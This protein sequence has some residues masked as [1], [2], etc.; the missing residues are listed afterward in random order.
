MKVA[1]LGLGNMGSGMAGNIL[2]AGHELTVWN[3]TE[4]KTEALASQGAQ[5]ARSIEKAVA[6][7]E[8]VVTCLM[9]D[10][11][12]LNSV[13]G[14]MLQSLPTNAVH[15]CATTIS[16]DCSEV[17]D[18][19]HQGHGSSYVAAP[20]IG[21]PDAAATGDLTSVL[22]GAEK[23]IERAATLADCYSKDLIRLPGSPSRGNI[24]KLC[25]NYSAI[26]IIE[27]MGE[28]YTLAENSDID[29]RMFENFYKSW[30]ATPILRMYAKKLNDRKFSDGGFVMSGGIKD[31]R[32]MLSTAETYRV[33][34]AIA[35]VVEKKMQDAIEHGL[36]RF[37]WSA[38]TEVTRSASGLPSALTEVN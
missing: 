28:V 6:G 36:S 24:F 22:A 31:V 13:D 29:P 20:V 27:L 14:V 34:F 32:L 2:R 37:D 18:G 8:I 19:L 12:V 26:S 9:N 15:M 10:Q 1:L 30:F 23:A 25:I 17:L 7:A 33:D 38:I 16:P 11:S 35:R 4:S 3:R 21:R 5:S